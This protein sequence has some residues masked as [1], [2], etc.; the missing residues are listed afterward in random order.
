[1]IFEHFGLL[2]GAGLL[3][4]VSAC[5]FLLGRKAAQQVKLFRSEHHLRF[6][7]RHHSR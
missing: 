2:I 4:L 3:A 7:G 6:Q 1:M 5:A